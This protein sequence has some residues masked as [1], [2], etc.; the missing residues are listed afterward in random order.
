MIK[1]TAMVFINMLTAQLT[2]VNG[3]MINNMDRVMSHGWTRANSLVF[4]M[5]PRNKVEVCT[6]GL[7]AICTLEIGLII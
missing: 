1:L 5:N 6:H 2:R 7:M 4:T 3:K